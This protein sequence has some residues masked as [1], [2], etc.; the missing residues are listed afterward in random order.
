MRLIDADELLVQMIG[1]NDGWFDPRPAYD[2][3]SLVRQQPTIDAAPVVHGRWEEPE[4]E[5]T[6]LLD[7]RVYAQCSVCKKE[8]YFGWTDKYCRDCGA[9]MDLK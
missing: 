3:E 9:K 8:S 2:C 5:S 1:M 4:S 7:K 6:R